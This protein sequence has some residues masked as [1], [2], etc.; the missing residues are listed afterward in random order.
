MLQSLNKIDDRETPMGQ[1]LRNFFISIFFILVSA[2]VAVGLHRYFSFDYLEA[3]TA[4][5]IGF[6]V[7]IAVRNNL[8][9]QRQL[10]QLDRYI[11]DLNQFEQSINKRFKQIE[12]DVSKLH[13]GTQEHYS[14]KTSLDSEG[15]YSL[16]KIDH[17]TELLD[18]ISKSQSDVDNGLPIT[19][20][21]NIDGSD[22]IIELNTR[23][24]Q[25]DTTA[26][27]NQFKI[28]PSQLARALAEE[29]TEL[30][31]QP[32]LEL[33]SRNTRYFEAFMRLRVGNDIVAA[34]QFIHAAEGSGQIARVDLLSLEMTLKVVRG[35]QRQ[36][37]FCPVFW[38]ISPHSLGNKKVF[39]EILEQLR[40]NQPLNRYL[41]CEIPHSIFTKL[42]RV[43][44]DNLALIRD[45]GFE[46]S[47]DNIV[48]DLP[49][50]MGLKS[51]LSL[52]LFNIIKIPAVELLRIGKDDI[53]NF[54][55]QIVPLALNNNITLIASEVEDDAQ[56]ISM[57]DAE[58]Y[59]AQ[60]NALMP[61]KAL[62][63]EL[64][65]P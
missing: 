8:V 26:A 31:L 28:D 52:G 51:I 23:L 61:A 58:V 22:N 27:E 5:S 64:G 14:D 30:F 50:D 54:A 2:G 15:T 36:D 4:A 20:V 18:G 53:T 63:K 41:I 62:K 19:Q 48:V 33:P 11:L 65:G 24:K 45:L 35:L 37:N 57:I 12:S 25:K 47:L 42:E 49:G 55:E 40:A 3:I 10:G 56:S 9:L 34:K 7:L 21:E 46:L 43:Q 38:N 39:Q 6:C 16:A 60:G 13:Q 32:I 44:R 17:A 59:L 1:R 29:N